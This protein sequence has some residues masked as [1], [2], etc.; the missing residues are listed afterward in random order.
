MDKDNNN[1]KEEFT[2]KSEYIC[3]AKRECCSVSTDCSALYILRPNGS[4]SYD[5]CGCK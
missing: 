5:G 3:K 1:K 2:T 4:E